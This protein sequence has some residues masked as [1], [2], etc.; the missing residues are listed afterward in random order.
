MQKYRRDRTGLSGLF[1]LFVILGGT[2]CVQTQ[3]T[4]FDNRVFEPVIRTEV[5][6]IATLVVD[7]CATGIH[8]L[9]EFELDP[10]PRA[11]SLNR[12]LRPS[13]PL[14]VKLEYGPGLTASVRYGQLEGPLCSTTPHWRD[15]GGANQPY[16]LKET[17]T[18]V[19]RGEFNLLTMPSKQQEFLLHFNGKAVLLAQR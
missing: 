10:S 14:P 15:E 7:S 17:C 9:V 11:M 13:Q 5:G 4:H 19:Y 2:G 8:A 1:I 6:D 16:E 18:Y 12:E 3:L